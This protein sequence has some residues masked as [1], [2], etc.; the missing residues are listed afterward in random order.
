[1]RVC[2]PKA[3]QNQQG[4]FLSSVDAGLVL[5][6]PS[7]RGAAETRPLQTMTLVPRAFCTTRCNPHEMKCFDTAE[8][9]RAR[10]LIQLSISA[11]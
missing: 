2:F 8:P 9:P 6:S 10:V 3:R 7:H 1:M 11:V 4:L 5:P